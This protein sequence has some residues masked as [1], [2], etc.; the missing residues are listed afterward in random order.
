VPLSEFEYLK[1][2]EN[3]PRLNFIPFAR[4]G[5]VESRPRIFHSG[6]ADLLFNNRYDGVHN[7]N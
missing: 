4:L 1:E 3:H 6:N 2:R 7:A 5:E